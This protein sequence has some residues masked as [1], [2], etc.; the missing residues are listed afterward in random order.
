MV[1]SKKTAVILCGGFGSRLGTLAKKLPKS[2]VKIHGFPILWYIIN[3][4]KDSLP[5]RVGL[6]A[7]SKGHNQEYIRQLYDYGQLDFGES[8]L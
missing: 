1:E 7:V 6:L 8:R 3:I 2:L 4:L 5:T